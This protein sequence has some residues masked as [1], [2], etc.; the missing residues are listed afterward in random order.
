MPEED[1]FLEAMIASIVFAAAF[2]V[3]GMLFQLW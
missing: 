1:E 2:G 3:I